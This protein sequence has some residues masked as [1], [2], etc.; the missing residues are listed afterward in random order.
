MNT[1]FMLAEILT[2]F[3]EGFNSGTSLWIK[4]DGEKEGHY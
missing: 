2:T 1:V 3:I 4:M